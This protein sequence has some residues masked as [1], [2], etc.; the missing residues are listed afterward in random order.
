MTAHGGG[1][2]KWKEFDK[3]G[4]RLRSRLHTEGGVVFHE[5]HLENRGLFDA[6]VLTHYVIPHAPTG[7][8]REVP[9]DPQA[10]YADA[11]KERTFDSLREHDWVRLWDLGDAVD[12]H[13]KRS[14]R[15][16]IKDPSG[17]LA[18]VDGVSL[19]VENPNY[20]PQSHTLTAQH[21]VRK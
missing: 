13:C 20:E 14:D 17:D 1:W 8:E 4:I 12:R 10:A 5:I 16:A 7:G 9:V 11:P 15:H 3:Y 6:E 2:T 18:Y 19:L 21:R